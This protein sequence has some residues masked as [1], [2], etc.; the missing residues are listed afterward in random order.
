MWKFKAY[1]YAL[2]YS[3]ANTLRKYLNAWCVIERAVSAVNFTDS[4]GLVHCQFCEI[5]TEIETEHPDCSH[6]QHF[7][8]LT[9]VKFHCDFSQEGSR[10]KFF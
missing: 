4:H 10:L 9:V 8:V 5:L 3:S 6:T 7:D 2:H 1:H